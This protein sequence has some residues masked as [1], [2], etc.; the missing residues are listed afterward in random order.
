M[1]TFFR[2]L[3][4]CIVSIASFFQIA[5]AQEK[6]IVSGYITNKSD[7]NRPLSDVIVY[8]YNTVAEAQDAYAAL[9]EA[10]KNKSWFSA[11]VV[12]EVYP[13]SGGYYEVLVPETGALLFYTGIADP[14]LE[15]V[16]YRLEINVAFSLNIILESSKVTAGSD[17]KLQRMVPVQRGPNTVFPVV[18]NFPAQDFGKTGIRLV[19]QSCLI[20]EEA[21][22]VRQTDYLPPMVY[23]GRQYHRTQ[24]RRMNYEGANDPLYVLAGKN[25]VLS[26][27]LRRIE[28]S[29]TIP[30]SYSKGRNYLKWKLWAEDYRMVVYADS[31]QFRTDRISRPMQFLEFPVQ[32]YYL[33]PEKFRKNP[34]RERRDMASNISLSFLIGQARLDPTDTAS[35]NSLER[36]KNDIA[37]VLADP[38][39]TLKEFHIVGVASP[40]GNYERNVALANKRLNFALDQIRAVL[41]KSVRDRVYMTT[42]ASVASWDSVADFLEQ[43]AMQ[44]EAGAIRR[45]IEKYPGSP[46]R[47]MYDIKRLAFYSDIIVPV[48]PKLRSISYS[49]VTEIYRELSRNEIYEMYVNDRAKGLEPEY[50]LYEYWHLFNM[51]KDEDELKRLYI[52]A[53][54]VSE[55]TEAKPWVLPANRL[56]AMCIEKGRIDTTLISPFI[57]TRFQC[58]YIIRDMN[59]RTEEMVNPEEVI[60]NMVTM[61]LMDKNYV[62]A[63]DLATMLPEKYNTLKAAAWCLSGRYDDASEKGRE[64]FVIM[65]NFSPRN[66]VVMNL[67]NGNMVLAKAALKELPQDD[68][69]T[70]YLSVQIMCNGMS[71]ASSSMDLETYDKA[72]AD[73]LY[74][75]KADPEFIDMA[76]RDY[77]ICEDLYKDAKRQY[78][79]PL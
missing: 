71:S 52:Q 37:D 55:K 36:L 50:P 64:Y 56:A 9:M 11:G 66:K 74:C 76:E 72:L 14:I 51:V 59:R 38:G 26:D 29:D 41:P 16:N 68:P 61:C 27:T 28:W 12:V 63:N 20:H 22:S 46:D 19:K 53:Y 34:R 18:Y 17:E 40:D 65:R 35:L 73:L 75:F 45:I 43:N 30:V 7:N 1:K 69:I 6:K 33:D 31:G 62:R 78:D 79:N 13:D 8:A 21:D 54:K 32:S 10:R 44:D 58:N 4:L 57:D 5:G 60:A 39:A 2:I 49:Y 67:A 25:P 3:L 24:L 77:T 23:D 48:L 42:K 47:Q 70:K 15:K